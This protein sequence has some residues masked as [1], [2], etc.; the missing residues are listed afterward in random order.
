MTSSSAIKASLFLLILCLTILTPS[1]ATTVIE[2]PAT[3]SL[4]QGVKFYASGGSDLEGN[5]ITA[6]MNNDGYTD[7][8]FVDYYYQGFTGI[9]YVVFGKSG[10]FTSAS[11]DVSSLTSPDAI[12]IYGPASYTFTGNT[13]SYAGDFNGDGKDDIALGRYSTNNQNGQGVYIIFGK[14]S[15]TDIYLSTL[16]STQGILISDYRSNSFADSIDYAGDVNG[17][18]I[19]DLIV[20]APTDSRK[21]SSC[22]SAYVFYGKSSGL[23]SFTLTDSWPTSSSA[24]FIV[25]GGQQGAIFGKTVSRAGDV[26]GDNIAD[27]MI[28]VPCAS[29]SS[30]SQAGTVYVI[31]GRSGSRA[32]IDLSTTSLTTGQGFKILGATA[33]D[34][35][36][37]SISY[38]GDINADGKDDVIVL[39]SGANNLGVAYVIYGKSGGISDIDLLTDL[40]TSKGFKITNTGN[41][42]PLN[43]VACAGD[44]NMDGVG[45]IIVTAQDSYGSRSNAGSLYI[46]YGKSGGGIGTVDFSTNVA[47]SQGSRIVGHNAGDQIGGIIQ[48]VTVKNNPDQYSIL[49]QT[50]NSNGIQV[51]LLRFDGKFSSDYNLILSR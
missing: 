17:D 24:G 47:V 42:A 19:D 46:V 35:L 4:A 2:L 18:G 29:P 45:D 25:F 34:Y 38:A 27:F 7:Y 31:Y 49:I 8:I 14:T 50:R 37:N 32:S 48:R 6:D 5:V 33:G 21:C 1:P 20:G 51:Y 11:I 41:V 13:A 40:T 39:A 44:L 10:G 23:S 9:T 30:R 15:M 36:G 16:T 28:G 22:G 3:L 26:N 43:K 12:R